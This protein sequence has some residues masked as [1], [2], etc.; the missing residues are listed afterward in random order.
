MPCHV[1]LHHNKTLIKAVFHS[2]AHTYK[3]LC[4]KYI[5]FNLVEWCV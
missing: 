4:I 5:E 3:K 1:V 2:S